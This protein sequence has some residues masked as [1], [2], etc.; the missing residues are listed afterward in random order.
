M[1]KKIE[2]IYQ[3]LSQ[4]EHVLLRPDTYVGSMNEI[5]EKMFVVEDIEKLSD[6][7]IKKELVKYVP[8]FIKIFDEIITNASDHYIRTGKVKY[9]KVSLDKESITIEND[10]PGIPVQIHKK[11]SM[12]LPELLFFNLLASSN[13]NDEEERFGAGRNGIGGKAVAILSNQFIL[14]TSDGKNKYIQI[15]KDNLYHKISDND[16]KKF[17]DK[18]SKPKISSCDKNYTKITYYPDFK[19]FGM[20]G[21]TEDVIKILAKRTLDVACYCPKAKVSFN[22]ETFPIKTMMDYMAMHLPENTELFYEKLNNEWEVGVASSQS[23]SF[24]QVSIVNGITTYRGGTGV[25]HISLEISKELAEMISSKKNKVTWVDVK[26]KLFLF[27]ICKIAN[28]TFDT[29]TKNYMTNPITKDILKDSKVSELLL[30]KIMKSDIVRAILEQIELKELQA[31]KRFNKNS[32]KEKVA[33]LIEAK[34]HDRTK[35]VLGIF[36]GD[37]AISAVRQFRDQNIFGAFPLRGKFINVSEITPKAILENEEARNLISS[38]GLSLGERVDL[39]AL[40]YARLLIYTDADCL[41][42]DTEIICKDGIKEIQDVLPTDYVLTHTGQYKK[43][44]CI[45]QSYKTEYI[46]I[47]ILGNIFYC[48][49]KHKIPVIRDNKAI[50]IAA[51]ELLYTDF[52]YLKDN[53]NNSEFIFKP[54]DSITNINTIKEEEFY[55]IEVEDDNTFFINGINHSIL[56]HNCDGDAISALLLNFFYTYWPELFEQKRICKVMTPLL[57]AKKGKEKKFFY[58]NEDYEAWSKK[59]KVSTWDI[60]YKKGL[61]SLLDDEYETIL[62]NPYMVII[63]P[64]KEAKENLKIWFDKKDTS[65]K[66]EKILN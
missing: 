27:L 29:Q 41:R 24:E 37:S 26:N 15:V 12:W 16:F 5:E 9:I 57:V 60:E 53:N 14:E 36:E 19:R 31:L 62:S 54:A 4:R 8:A 17:I 66:K 52:L 40:Q 64:D 13:F 6:V 22:D 34:G 39:K 30:K 20:D 3:K 51:G 45:I 49:Q 18:N 7:K 44:K 33:K 21:F 2:D 65:G 43:V 46:K 25:N 28:P 59:E 55:D 56:S 38:I 42:Y 58:T 32:K 63:N 23:E 61:A 47:Q 10:G 1:T 50:D 11:E 35:C 48:S